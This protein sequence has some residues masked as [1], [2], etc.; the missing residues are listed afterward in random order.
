MPE[1]IKQVTIVLPETVV[2]EAIRAARQ[3][4]VRPDGLRNSKT[5]QLREW[6]LKGYS[7]ERVTNGQR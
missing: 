6:L 5:A 4:R 2:Q 3:N 1:P 7:A